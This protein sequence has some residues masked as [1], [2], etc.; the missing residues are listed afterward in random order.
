MNDTDATLDLTLEQLWIYPVK[1]CAG[2]RLRAVELLET[3]LEWDRT[4]MVVDADGEFVSQRELPRMA[5]IQPRFRMGQLELRAPGM[6]SLHLAL[7]AAERPCRVR[8]WDDTVDA[9][10]MG[11]I[12][13]QWFT[14][15]LGPDLPPGMG[16]LRLVR[17]DPDERRLSPARWTGGVEAPNTFSDGFPVLVLSAASLADVNER[18]ALQG[19]PPVG[20]ERFRPNVVIGGVGP[21]DEDRLD[22]IAWHADAAPDDA[23]AVE[24][25]LVKPCAR[26]SI[27]DVDPTTGAPDGRVSPLLRTYRQDRR[28]MGAV[29]LGMNAIVRRGDGQ[30]L[31]EGMRGVGHWGAW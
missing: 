30:M 27:P 19:L 12:A 31:H 29:T 14:D 24:L 22:R 18:L 16:P 26:C 3:G 11:D 25:R 17:F 4:W 10:D 28:L 15:F 23:P 1:S 21:Y 5:L 9:Y 6:L 20:V 2:I 13:A 8:V 7:D